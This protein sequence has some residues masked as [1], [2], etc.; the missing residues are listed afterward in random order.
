MASAAETKGQMSVLGPLC[1]AQFLATDGAV[2]KIKITQ[3][4]HNDVIR[5]FVKK[6]VGTQ[7]DYMSV[8][9]GLHRRGHSHAIAE[10]QRRP[11]WPLG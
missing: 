4:G 6:I 9:S 8:T 1:V 11:R 3:Y 5:E 2:A 10:R 7:M